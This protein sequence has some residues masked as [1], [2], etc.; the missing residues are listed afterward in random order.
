MIARLHGSLGENSGRDWLKEV[1]DFNGSPEE[2]ANW[3]HNMGDDWLPHLFHGC[4]I[5]SRAKGTSAIA[6]RWRF[7]GLYRTTAGSENFSS[8]GVSTNELS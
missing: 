2:A 8:A 6:S 1:S 7:M 5:A 3:D 4:S